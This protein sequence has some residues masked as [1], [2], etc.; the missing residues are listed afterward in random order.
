MNEEN[1]G[2]GLTEES[3]DRLLAQHNEDFRN[4]KIG[5]VGHGFVGKAVDYAFNHPEVE[6]F[7]VDPKC[8]TTIDELLDWQPHVTF[9]CAPTPMGDDGTVDASIV[10]DAVLKLLEHTKGGV[11]IK[12][13]IPPDVV[14]RIF[15]S[16]FEDDVKRLTVNP[17]FL[18]ESNS[19]EQFVNAPHHIIGG[20]PDA[21]RGLATLYDIYSLCTATDFLFMSASEAAFV[22]Y[23]VNAFLATKVTFF[24]QFF[25]SV[26]NYGCNYPTIIKALGRDSRIGHS[27]TRV[28]GYDGKRGFGGACFPKDLK[29]FTM[30]DPDL[31]LIEK[32]VSINNDYR[33]QYE[34]DEREES[35][36]VKYNGQTEE[37]QQDQDNGSVVGE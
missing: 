36:N 14:D 4:L 6:K 11:V 19:K 21:V 10:E 33:K 1:Q 23:G 32:C 24:N 34:L 20:H 35:N 5:I 17:E 15:N 26:N 16:V 7:Y 31:T 27:H 25:D 3:A 37:E 12:S 9:V 8:D 22:K 18:T 13:T 30:F 2:V 28:P 29:A